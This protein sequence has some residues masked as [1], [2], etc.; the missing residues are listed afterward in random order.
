MIKNIKKAEKEVLRP[1]G[2][3]NLQDLENKT[4]DESIQQNT[5]TK[6]KMEALNATHSEKI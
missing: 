6:S 5:I 2:I 4:G 3:N 1:L